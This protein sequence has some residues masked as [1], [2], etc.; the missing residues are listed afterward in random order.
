[1]LTHI[2]VVVFPR[3]RLDYQTQK[4]IIKVSVFER[5]RG[6]DNNI[7]KRCLGS[8]PTGVC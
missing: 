3:Y 4:M 1:M 8:N 2:V 5:T 7:I 6:V